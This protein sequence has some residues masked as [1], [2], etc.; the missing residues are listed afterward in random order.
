MGTL[1][2]GVGKFCVLGARKIEDAVL[3]LA[4]EQPKSLRR[5]DAVDPEFPILPERLCPVRR[6][7]Q[8][9]AHAAE[10]RRVLGFLQDYSCPPSANNSAE[11]N[12]VPSAVS[13]VGERSH[14]TGGRPLRLPL[15]PA[16]P[17]PD[18]R[19]RCVFPLR[20]SRY[21]PAQL[22]QS[23]PLPQICQFLSILPPPA[24]LPPPPRRPAPASRGSRASA[25]AQP[26]RPR[27]SSRDSSSA[28]HFIRH[29]SFSVI[30]L[31]PI[32]FRRAGQAVLE[33]F[34]DKNVE[35]GYSNQGD[36]KT[37]DVTGSVKRSAVRVR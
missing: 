23:S 13:S 24:P 33:R 25:G 2:F 16:N 15:K 30:F 19:L 36:L 6:E 7:P 1:T 9:L 10:H 26:V 12:R 34:V 28:Q 8:A 17:V 35:K 3:R 37:G 22:P 14:R 32:K 27:Q 4:R 20:R 21:R 31:Y 29:S 11:T 5:A 18:S